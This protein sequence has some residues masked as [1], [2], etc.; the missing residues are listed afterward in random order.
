ISSSR[1]HLLHLSSGNLAPGHHKKYKLQKSKSRKSLQAQ[2]Q[3]EKK[4]SSIPSSG[5]TESFTKTPEP[6]SLEG[7]S[8]DEGCGGATA[9]GEEGE[10]VNEVGDSNG[11][12][13]NERG[14]NTSLARQPSDRRQDLSGQLANTSGTSDHLNS[15]SSDA[16]GYKQSA[17]DDQFRENVKSKSAPVSVNR[18]ESY[19]ERSQKKTR[20]TRRKHPIRV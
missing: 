10:E 18:S 3:Q 16:Y 7:E 8:G 11:S 1:S 9:G 5:R 20:T 6:T 12:T 2:Q 15:S 13:G 4:R 14:T 17:D 19:K